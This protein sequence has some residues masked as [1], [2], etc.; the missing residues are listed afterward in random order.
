MALIPVLKKLK[1]AF[2][3]G[4]RQILGFKASLVYRGSSRTAN[5]TE[6]PCLK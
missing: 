2:K 6:K 4:G 5:A 1:Q 3:M